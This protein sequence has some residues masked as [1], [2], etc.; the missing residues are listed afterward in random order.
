MRP[1]HMDD[2][3]KS[4]SNSCVTFM[5]LSWKLMIQVDFVEALS[6]QKRVH[7][8]LS[9]PSQNEIFLLQGCVQRA[10]NG[11][12]NLV[13]VLVTMQ[14]TAQQVKQVKEESEGFATLLIAVNRVT[15][16]LHEG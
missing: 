3:H 1:T 7:A 2:T 5:Y 9:E 14:A 12:E 13:T 16:P 6:A 15:W 4:R 8:F 11:G 10:C